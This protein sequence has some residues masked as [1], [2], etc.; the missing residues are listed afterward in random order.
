MTIL[1]WAVIGLLT[2][3]LHSPAMMMSPPL[4]P[5]RKR[6]G[7]EEASKYP[8]HYNNN[9]PSQETGGIPSLGILNEPQHHYVASVVTPIQYMDKLTH[10]LTNYLASEGDNKENIDDSPPEQQQHHAHPQKLL[11]ASIMA[12]LAG[13]S[14]ALCL[15]RFNCFATMMTGNTIMMSLSLAEKRWEDALWRTSLIGSYLV[16][17][18]SIQ[19]IEVT[20]LKWIVPILA[21]IFSIAD[22]LLTFYPER[23][24]SHAVPIL[25]LGYGMIYTYVYQELDRNSADAITGHIMMLGS[26][27][28]DFFLGLP[29]NF[30]QMTLSSCVFVS[31]VVGCILGCRLECILKPTSFPYF[32][33]LGISYAA[34][35]TMYLA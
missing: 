23:W 35:F 6:G 21:S 26:H 15:H 27:V 16:G 5:Q 17:A 7:P 31:L 2:S 3:P 25:A 28:S 9:E 34:V 13:I 24:Q 10:Y 30:E 19:S 20:S 14:D 32:A 33:L 8:S 11:F 1:V 29:V 18:V 12:L 4:P 22:Y